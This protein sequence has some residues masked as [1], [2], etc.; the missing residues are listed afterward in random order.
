MLTYQDL[1]EVGN[2][3]A[4]RQDF[5]LRVINE[6]K[7]SQLYKEACIAEDYDKGKNR[8]ISEY[9]KLLYTITGN[10]VPDNYSANYKMP[11]KFFHRFVLQ[12]SQFL[13]GNG[14]I[15]EDES[16]KHKLGNDFDKQ[17]QKLGKNA[18]IGGVAFGFFNLDHLES[19]KVTEFAPLYDEENGALSAGV[20]FWQIDSSKPLRATLYELDGYTDYLWKDGECFVVA[21]KRAYI[22]KAKSTKADGTYIYDYEN[23]ENFPIIPL[24]GNDN[25]QSELTGGREQIDCYDLIKSGFAN[26]V[27]DASQIYWVLQNAGGMDDIDLAQFVQKMHKLKAVVLDDGVQ[28]ESH[29][30]EVPYNSRE[31]LL[32]RLE[33]DLYKDFMALDPEHIASGSVTATQIK[34]AYE[35]L[36][37]KVDDWE[38]CVREFVDEVLKL[39][40]YEAEDYSFTRSQIV[41]AQEEIQSVLSAAQY[42]HTD[43]VTRKLLV[44]LGDGEKAEDMLELLNTDE[45]DRSG[46]ISDDSNAQNQED[47]QEDESS[48]NQA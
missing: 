38:Y 31:A 27:D 42:L 32:S 35:P 17:L 15:F 43:Y 44:L 47:E 6:H 9:Q 8:T 12:E 22:T 25:H 28:A 2:N 23:Y 21:E 4:N 11:S 36:N 20:R 26:D 41:N 46:L 39:A 13:L 16:I 40:G 37:S 45:L 5:V 33:K 3:E 10:A 29:T 18:L 1:I 30:Q 19:F 24:W 14:I 34:A 48:E 7:A